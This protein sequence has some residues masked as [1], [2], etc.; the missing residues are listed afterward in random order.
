MNVAGLLFLLVA[1]FLTGRGLLQLFKLS[2]K[3]LFIVCFSLLSGVAI[4]SFLPFIAEL[5]HV[6]ITPT[7]MAIFIG[8]TTIGFCVPL[9]GMLR[10]FKMPA[11]KLK[12][13]AIYELPFFIILGLLIFLS[14]WRAYYYP[15]NARDMTSGPEVMA[16]LALKEKHIINSLFKI[17]LQS[18]NNYL[19][20]P[21]ITSLQIIYKMFVQPFGQT[22]LSI[23][24]INFVIVTY[25]LLKEKLHPLIAGFLMLFFFG[26]P[27]VFGYSYLML[28]DY[29]NMVF[30]FFGFYFLNQYLEQKQWN[31]LGFSIFLFAIAT[32]VRTETLI[33]IGMIVPYFFIVEWRQKQ[34]IRQ[35]IMK[36]GLLLAVPFIVYFLCM[37]VYVKHYIPIKYDV[38]KDVNPHLENVGM[39]I[40]RLVDM[41][42]KLIFTPTGVIYYGQFVYLFVIILVVDVAVFR[43]Y[44]QERITALYGIG[45]VYVGLAFIGYLLPLADLT[46]TTKRG[47]FKMF[48]LILLYY[49]NSGILLKVTEML[50]NWEYGIKT[51]KKATPVVPPKP[52][53]AGGVTAARQSASQLPKKKK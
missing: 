49:R 19:K 12:L 27:E 29:S 44:T 33:L 32:Y 8:V 21:F 51:E 23:I 34:P 52:A 20:P 9:I 35:S 4:F 11:I 45:L 26:M 17:D 7:N 46:H 43:K 48:P 22:W 15:P 31:Y 36:I 6:D 2:L 25:T 50:N 10:Q 3:P 18:T 30:F 41:S 28:F 14:V 38:S 5:V 53:S 40:D 47:L 13:P 37:N 24:F 1:Q 42:N 16:E 39:F